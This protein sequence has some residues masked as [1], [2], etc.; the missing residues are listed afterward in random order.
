MFVV[1]K[2][3]IP[4]VLQ[5]AI[6]LELDRCNCVFSAVVLPRGGRSRSSLHWRVL[7]YLSSGFTVVDFSETLLSTSVQPSFV[8]GTGGIL[9]P[10]QNKRFWSAWYFCEFRWSSTVYWWL[11][12]LPI[13]IILNVYK[14]S[15]FVLSKP[16]Q[17]TKFHAIAMKLQRLEDNKIFSFWWFPTVSRIYHDSWSVRWGR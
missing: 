14:R 16:F 10:L 13:L 17:I 15:L 1:V 3:R 5:N 6:L 11:A 9:P 4:A 12:I 7:C 8:V 2:G